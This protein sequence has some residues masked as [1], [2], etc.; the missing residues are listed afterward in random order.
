[1]NDFAKGVVLTFL[2]LMIPVLPVVAQT[3]GKIVGRV[4]DATNDDPMSGANIH[5][6]GTS[7]GSSTD[8]DG[9]YFILRVPPG[10][11][12]IEVSYVGYKTSVIENVSV[13][14][15]LTTTLN[16]KMTPTAIQ[17]GEEVIYIAERP[18]VRKD[19]TSMESHVRSEDIELMP[20]EDLN[21]VLDMQAGVTRDATGGL[22]IRGGRSTEVNYLVNGISITDDYNKGQALA[23]A[24]EAIA[25]L[26]I[27]SGTFNAEYGNAMSGIINL[28]TKGG[29]N[30]YTGRVE[31][32][33]GDYVSSRTEIFPH[34]DSV[35][36]TAV[37]NLTATLSGPIVRDK[38]TFF[39]SGRRSQNDG[40]IYG[41]RR[42]LPQ[43]RGRIVNDSTTIATLGDGA[44]VPMNNNG[45][46]NGQAVLQWQISPKMV[47]KSDFLGS[48]AKRR[49]YAHDYRYDPDGYG[50]NHDF[51]H[52][53]M[54][55]F[56][57]MFSHKTFIEA[58][59]ANRENGTSYSLY[60]DPTD[61]RYVHPDSL[62]HPSYTFRKAGTD[63]VFFKR[64]TTSRIAKVDWTSQVNLQHQVKSGLDLQTD[65]IFYERFTLIPAVDAN[66]QE[67]VPFQPSVLDVS[68]ADHDRYVRT[69]WKFAGYVQ[70]KI[71]F[72]SVV[73]NIGLRYDWFDPQGKIPNDAADPNIYRP[74]K[75]SHKYHDLNGDGT[76][77]LAEQVP[78]NEFSLAERES[79][80]YH[81]TTTKSQLSPRF[82]IAYP[83]TDKGV[84]HFSYGIFQQIPEYSLLF[85]SDE[86]K[87]FE[88]AKIYGPF[89]NPDLKP[90]RTTMYEIGLAQQLT[91]QLAINIT[92]FSRDIR[93]WISS[94]AQIPTYVA[95]VSYVTM[96]NRDLANIRGVTVQLEGRISNQ[97]RITGDY[98]LQIAEGTNSAPEDEYWAQLNEEEPTKVLTPLNWDQRHTFN[99]T[100]HYGGES[101]GVTVLGRYNSGHPYTPEILTGELTGRSILAGLAENSR[102]MPSGF[103]ID[104][105]AYYA[106]DIP[107]GKIQLSLQVKNLFD[108]AN[109]TS[110]F[111]DTGLAN[112]TVN[113][114]LVAGAD[115]GYF[116]RPDY[117]SEPRS[118]LLGV[119]YEF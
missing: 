56:T 99:L 5:I 97:F 12:T 22:H 84:I 46:S 105:Y 25:E 76:I 117:Y 4:V 102:R 61:S 28:V 111:R 112:Y 93:N 114:S 53:E 27:I 57:Y 14:I 115:E 10:I 45:S 90:Q 119:R 92:G 1:M 32:E 68:E 85:D 60:D 51:G 63:T 82:G 87:L 104:L 54:S 91:D 86:R 59:L 100:A 109:P 77:D 64:T 3:G 73:I 101:Y 110:V 31:T 70:D 89:G 107:G 7:L 11:C 47:L 37:S 43:G 113:E 40:W 15:G 26:Q 108:A 36:P 55:K 21:D 16:V 2:L 34:I 69:P 19:Q 88:A 75:L 17:A 50:T 67:I 23:V 38:L 94:S 48:V 18:L 71:E 103:N 35:S 118:M 78:E 74:L 66:G 96:I 52:T 24:N 98:T 65:R 95:G 58:S 62:L 81:G 20:V 13:S 6:R 49:N 8:L 9:Q 72:E 116:I 41:E 30:T 106:I 29:S 39:V 33:F 44:W 79:F 80:W 83:I 42:Y